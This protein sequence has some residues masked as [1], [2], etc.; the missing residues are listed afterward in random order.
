MYKS[1]LAFVLTVLC[2]F[3]AL[4]CAQAQTSQIPLSAVANKDGYS[5]HWLLPER[6]IQLYRP[7]LAIVIRPGARMYE[8]NSRVEFSDAAPAYVNGDLLV[9]PSLAKRLARLASMAVVHHSSTVGDSSFA[10]PITPSGPV[11]LAIEPVRGSDALS[12]SG[13]A[14]SSAPVTIT[15]LA[16][17]SPDLPTVL[18]SRHEVLPSANGQYQATISYAPDFLQNT[19]VQVVATSPLGVTP[20]T[21]SVTVASANAGLTVPF[22]KPYCPN[23]LCF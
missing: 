16:Q 21:A 7:G 9:S 3:G 11:T 20:A 18:L 12:V 6:A 5:L 22:D 19:I 1:T 14:P 2:T 4:H 10:A 23:T 13:R 17:I 15:L 8:V